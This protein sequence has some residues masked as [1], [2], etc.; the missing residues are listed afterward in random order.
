MP[1]DAANEMTRKEWRE[2]GFFYDRNDQQKE[3]RLIGSRSGLLRFRDALL[4]YAEDSS[5]DYQSEHEHYG[6]YWYLEIMTWPEPGFDD[7]AI[8]GSLAD[9]KRLA[10]IIE[11]RLATARV[12]DSV[13]I[14]DEFAANTPYALILEL[15]ED[16]FDPAQADPMLPKEAG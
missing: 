15:R 16:G 12:G 14:R 11:N 13:C 10:V 7:H 9:L 5:N 8:H 6:P 1:S 3:W 4:E 2:L